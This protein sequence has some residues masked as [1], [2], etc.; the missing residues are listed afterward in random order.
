LLSVTFNLLLFTLFRFI[1]VTFFSNDFAD[2]SLN[3]ILYAFWVGFRFDL[4]LTIIIHLPLFLLAGFKFIGLFKSLFGKRIWLSYL[5]LVNLVIVALYITNLF[6]YDFFKHPLDSSVIRYLYD[7]KDAMTMVSEGYPIVKIGAVFIVALLFIYCLLAKMFFIADKREDSFKSKKNKFIVYTLF[8]LVFIFAAYG[9]FELYPW[10]WSEAFYSANK[11][12]SYLASNPVTYFQNTLKNKGEKYN[13]SETKKSYD[14]IAELLEVTQKDREKLNFTRV[15]TP[16]H[17][18]EYQFKKPNIIFFLGESTSFARSNISNNPLDATPFLKEMSDNGLSYSRYYTPHAGTARG[19]WVTLT[20]LADVENM[21][22]SSRNP[23]VVNQQLILNSLKD[24]KKYYFIGGSLSW[25]NVRGVV[26]NV[27]GITKLE[28]QDYP[29][30]PHNDVWGISD[31]HLAGE[32]NAILKEEK[33]PFFAFVQ[34]A[35]NHS[36]NTIPEENFGFV[37]SENVAGK[38]DEETLLKY[39]FDGKINELDGQRFL[40]HSV[41]RLVTLAKK[42]AYFDNTIFIFVGDHGLNRRG[43]HMHQAE[44]TFETATLHTP[45]IIYAP[46]LIKKAKKFD[47]PVSPVDIMATIAGLTGETYTNSTMGRDLL[48]KD[49]ESKPHFSFYLQHG[50]NP[51]LNIITK[52][53]LFR[54]RADGTNKELH[55]YYYE[56]GDENKNLLK[57]DVERASKMEKV[58]RGIYESTRYIR[59]NN[60]TEHIQT[61]INDLNI[62]PTTSTEKQK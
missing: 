26:S 29:N 58:T 37:K 24:Y 4:Q 13:L 42:E 50:D 20:G 62:T 32:V 8:F 30:S 59:Y 34:L 9:K 44:Q 12:L 7:Y 5:L 48:D 1:F 31:A 18:P 38:T 41:K 36:P 40:D 2:L 35:G 27:K 61:L 43:D 60:S 56:K 55:K 25:G 57:E 47:Y 11:H 15:I 33:Q 19:V 21:R 6:Y 39:S 45:L 46:K 28:E 22:T 51:L 17:E 52:D 3:K 16:N 49:F 54:M 53:Y 23:M 10:R 14:I